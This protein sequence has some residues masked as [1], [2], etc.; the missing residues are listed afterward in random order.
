L[1][2]IF[3]LLNLR[4]DIKERIA[5]LRIPPLKGKRGKACPPARRTTSAG[6]PRLGR[7]GSYEGESPNFKMEL[8]EN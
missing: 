2:G 6:E 4:G 8:V 3:K 7:R 5:T 1:L